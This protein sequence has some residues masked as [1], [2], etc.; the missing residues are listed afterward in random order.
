MKTTIPVNERV[1]YLKKSLIFE[2]APEETLRQIA[3]EMNPLEIAPG[4]TVFYK[5]DKAEN[6][7]VIVKGL[8]KIHDG[9]NILNIMEDKGIFGEYALIGN[10]DRT[11]SVTCT[12]GGMLLTLSRSSFYHMLKNNLDITLALMKSLVFRITS[13]K[14]KS[15]KLL[16]NILPYE[17]AEEL[18]VKGH[19][20]VKNIE[21]ATVLFTDFSGFTK[22]SEQISADKLIEE[23]NYCFT[24]FD[25]II[26]KYG[27]E[28]IKTI[29]D[30]YMCV[31]GIPLENKS[32]PIDVSLAAI[33]IREFMKKRYQEKSKA[34]INYWKCRI[35]INTGHVIA[36][37][38]GIKKF[39][40][41]IWSDTV[42]TAS[43]MESSSEPGEINITESTYHAISPFFECTH[44]GAMEVKGKGAVK[45][46]FL[47]RIKPTYSSDDEG[48]CPSKELLNHIKVLQKK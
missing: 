32:N 2:G 44:R 37:I 20:N 26:S 18:K 21:Y 36:G 17:I 19:V 29:G 4:Q 47:N 14:D 27:I 16:Q 39:A 5:G 1:T 45:M 31:G 22:I 23:L 12:H 11:A 34:G 42:N 33:E 38:V 28:K 13:E 40:Y 8:F 9:E 15:E 6:M 25:N 48:I 3:L 7:Y 41:D 10:N 30:A 46:F 24:E 35:G 43:R